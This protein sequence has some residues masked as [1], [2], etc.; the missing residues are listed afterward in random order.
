[1][2]KLARLLITI[3]VIGASFFMTMPVYAQGINDC[4]E[5]TDPKLCPQSGGEAQIQTKIGNVLRTVYFWIGIIAV[6]V[7]VISGIRYMTSQGNAEAVKK[8]KSGITYAVIGLI[9][10]LAAF[11]IT[12]VIINAL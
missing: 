3:A 7:I 6:V 2:K 4:P 8:A 9:V 10:V 11:A 5:N 12:E 1:M